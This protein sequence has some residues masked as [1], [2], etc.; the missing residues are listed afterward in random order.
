LN[1]FTRQTTVRQVINDPAFGDFGRLL[2]PVDRPIDPDQ[3]L[4]AISNERTFIWY[5][6]INADTTVDVLN[7]LQARASA[8]EQI[9][10]PI[11]S[12]VEQRQDPSRRNTGLFFFRGQPEK[13]FAL[14]N[15]GGGFM[16]VAALHDSFP[17][18]LTISRHGHP[19]FALIYR[20]DHPFEDLGRALS[21]IEDHAETLGVKRTGY[22]L[23]GGSAGA[24]MAAIGGNRKG[25]RQIT[26]RTDLPAAAAVI[27][28]YTGYDTVSK[29]DA[30]TYAC[31]GD[32][33]GIAWW[34]GMKDRLA[35]LDRSGV[36]T[37]FHMYPGRRHGFGLGLHTN[38][39]GWIEDAL[40]FWERMTIQNL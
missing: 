10:Y 27:M 35:R 30:P 28:Q 29:D 2:F 26:G 24:R 19:A 11:Y 5:S 4:A 20:P 33:D 9:F 12:A 34:Q 32:R 17:Q 37:E 18:A 7:D 14:V 31:V 25:L 23:W 38:A 13:E 3:S 1:K 6:E 36:P 40:A 39:E 21:F 22:S 8:G 16:Y 15:A